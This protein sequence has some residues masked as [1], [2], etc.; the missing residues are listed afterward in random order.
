M[1]TKLQILAFKDTVKW[2]R[3]MFND[4]IILVNVAN[5]QKSMTW[6]TRKFVGITSSG[7]AAIHN[8]LPLLMHY[9][10]EAFISERAWTII[11]LATLLSVLF[12]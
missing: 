5:I 10:Y 1:H 4:V 2:R 7:I 6:D 9:F 12:S 3:Y 11:S 8:I